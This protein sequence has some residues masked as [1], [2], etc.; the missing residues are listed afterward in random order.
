MAENIFIFFFCNRFFVGVEFLDEGVSHT[1]ALHFS[2]CQEAQQVCEAEH[3]TKLTCQNENV[4]TYRSCCLAELRLVKSHSEI[5][6][7]GSY[8]DN[9]I[10]LTCWI[11]PSVILFRLEQCEGVIV[12]D[13]RVV[14]I[15][16]RFKQH[17]LWNDFKSPM[18]KLDLV[19]RL[20][21]H[22]E[23]RRDSLIILCKRCRREELCLDLRDHGYGV[24][25]F[26]NVSI[27]LAGRRTRVLLKIIARID[28]EV[29][30]FSI[31]VPVTVYGVLQE[32]VF[33]LHVW[34][35]EAFNLLRK[36]RSLHGLT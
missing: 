29:K 7:L 35:R 31:A 17:K 8:Q 24:N 30:S 25:Y 36:Q 12:V 10:L 3:A 21:S 22:I 32:H 34:A 13:H 33:A 1:K 27:R 28:R 5:A 2:N 20:P 9:I 26:H 14:V 4:I 19:Q 11:C 18:H 16:S 15:N 6:V 23:H